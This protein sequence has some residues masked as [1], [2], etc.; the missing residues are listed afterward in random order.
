MAQRH[1]LDVLI[2]PLVWIARARGWRR[3][4]LVGAS[5]VVLGGVGMLIGREAALWQ[6]PNV[7][8]PVDRRAAGQVNLADADNAM[9]FYRRALDRLADAGDGDRVDRERAALGLWLEGTRCPD[10]LVIQ[11]AD[12]AGPSPVGRYQELFNLLGLA[13]GEWNRRQVAGDLDGAWVI[14][15]GMI[16]T[17]LHAGRH[18]GSEASATSAG[19]LGRVVNSVD[20][21]ASH[22]A[23]TSVGIRRALADLKGLEA[24]VPPL[25][26]TLRVESFGRRAV[27]LQEGNHPSTPTRYRIAPDSDWSNQFPGAVWFRLFWADEPRRSLRLDSVIL[28]GQLAHCDLPPP[29]DRPEFPRFG[30]YAITPRTPPQV[31]TIAPATLA[32]LAD[33]SNL[34]IRQGEFERMW[35]NHRAALW[36]ILRSVPVKL[37]VAAHRLDHPDHPAR[38]IRDLVGP[39]LATPPPGRD[40]L[41]GRTS[42]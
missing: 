36:S 32:G 42:F 27:L 14:L 26:A 2:A 24:M 17:G 29:L 23:N 25:S 31:A 11:P 38:S 40:E 22:P 8:D 34:M 5:A 28:A 33:E 20:R 3:Q 1:W 12:L 35:F 18:G 6:I 7:P 21:W 16:R 39:Y 37:A 30:V 19:I 15:R 13:D 4:T 9:T 41:D 10:A